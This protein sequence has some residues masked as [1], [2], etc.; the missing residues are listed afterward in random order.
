MTKVGK[1]MKSV[2]GTA[3]RAAAAAATAV[4]VEK[5]TDAVAEKVHELAEAEAKPKSA[6]LRVSRKRTAAPALKD[7]TL[8][9]KASSPKAPRRGKKK[10]TRQ[11]SKR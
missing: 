8:I 2:A 9:K 10:I 3:L 4:V 7:K 1:V 11:E 6:L 5:M